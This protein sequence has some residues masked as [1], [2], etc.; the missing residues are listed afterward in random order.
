[1]SLGFTETK[2]YEIVGM[3]KA[4]MSVNDI[5][6]VAV[7]SRVTLQALCKCYEATNG[8]NLKHQPG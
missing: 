8:S 6:K 1:M 7:M 3:L 2:H 4:G 5:V